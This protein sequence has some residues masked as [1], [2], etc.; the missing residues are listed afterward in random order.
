[1][2]RTTVS[3]LAVVAV[4]AAVAAAAALTAPSPEPPGDTTGPVASAAR[5]PVERTTLTCPR[6]WD[7]EFGTTAYT[8]FT[9]RGTGAAGTGNPGAKRGEAA[10]TAAGA[11]A[12]GGQDGA[13]D[14]KDGKDKDANGQDT[15]GRDTGGQDTGGQADAGKDKAEDKDAEGK[16]DGEGERV[17]PLT[18]P[19][20]PA[21][22][23]TDD[24]AAPALIGTADGALAPGYTVQQTTEVS[25][26]EG[27]GLL[28]TSCAAPGAEF[29]F[30]G[31]STAKDR[32]DYA[33][34]TNP[35][36]TAAVVDLELYGR[37]GAI[38]TPSGDGLTVPAHATVPV[39]LSTLTTSEETNLTL[40][41]LAR[42]GRVGAAVEAVDTGLGGDW[43][44]PSAVP[45]GSVVLPGLPKDT[46]AARLVV[47][48]PGEDDADLKVRLA[49]PTGS[50]SPAGFETL[51]V[52]NGMTTAVD[53]G[54][55]TQGEAASIVLTPADPDR[56]TPV[57]AAVRV[58]RGTEG[59][60]E[61]A[62]VAG[63]A[64]V[65]DRAGA[66]GSGPLASTLYLTAPGKAAK[67]RVTSSAATGGGA[68]QTRT[69][70]VKAGTTLA[71]EPPRPSGKGLYAVTVEPVSGGPVHAARMLAKTGGGVPMFTLQPMPD[72][73]ATVV[74]PD[75]VQDLSVLN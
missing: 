32:R 58:L 59:S 75:A 45:A 70:E 34:L 50:I 36:D 47:F 67:V 66:A 43:I 52:K 56:A 55:V 68:P 54:K 25:A 69:V 38:D 41:V 12:P 19:G 27:R 57:V 53:L 5:K 10:L 30:A 22:A 17:A 14:K 26:G 64:A 62:F 33:H 24:A 72:D 65:E 8:A 63:T 40:H 2:K 61:S 6:P 13:G 44:P 73:R 28:G 18:V 42:A 7:A 21:T 1:M 15:G 71:L 39:L 31:A 23:D 60:Q 11:E 29:W 46:E 48:A 16:Q 9:P 20:K 37:E 35:D 3:L 51:H 4:L 74:V 49:T